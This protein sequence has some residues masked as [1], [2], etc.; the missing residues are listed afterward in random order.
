MRQNANRGGIHYHECQRKLNNCKI[1]LRFRNKRTIEKDV[2][3][4]LYH[5]AGKHS[6]EYYQEKIS[7]IVYKPS[8]SSPG[9]SGTAEASP[10]VVPIPSSNLIALPVWGS[11]PFPGLSPPVERGMNKFLKN[12]RTNAEDQSVNVLKIDN[13]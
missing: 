2:T 4:T 5:T 8:C 3:V 12:S 10:S 9:P 1:L 6:V 7:E 11:G 13:F